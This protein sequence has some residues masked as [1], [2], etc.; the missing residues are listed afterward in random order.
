MI[1]KPSSNSVKPIFGLNFFMLSSNKLILSDSL[2][3]SSLA[4]LI[5]VFPSANIAKI[6]IKGISSIKLGI[7]FPEI[8][9][10]FKFVPNLAVI[11]ALGSLDIMQALCNSIFAPIS[12]RTFRKA[13]LV[14]FIPMPFKGI[15]LF[16]RIFAAIRYAA[17]EKSLGTSINFFVISLAPSKIILLPS[18]KISASHSCNK[19]SV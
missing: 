16:V 13:V 10:P 5:V 19:R 9:T 6:A 18:L 14:L 2:Y 17:E 11:S 12:S 8:E 1:S 7:L 4:S 15:F 3:L